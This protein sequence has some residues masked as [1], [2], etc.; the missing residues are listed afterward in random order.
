MPTIYLVTNTIDGKRYIGQTRQSL[1]KRWGQHCLPDKRSKR[2]LFDAIVKHGREHFIIES[3]IDVDSQELADEFESEYIQRYLTLVPN[4]YNLRTGGKVSQLSPETKLKISRKHKGK[5]LSEEHKQKIKAGVNRPEVLARVATGMKGKHHT[6]ETRER[7]RQAH[8]GKPA[9]WKS[10]EWTEE[11][12]LAASK[13]MMGNKHLLGHFPSEETRRKI[14]E[15]MKK[16][17]EEK[18]WSSKHE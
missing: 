8:L 18:F 6:P 2:Y 1:A 15:S 17:R 4:G 7:M 12:K 3:L 11:Q 9:P 14:S 16:A 10:V 5:K 13:R